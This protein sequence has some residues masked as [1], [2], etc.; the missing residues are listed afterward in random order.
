M[1]SIINYD[2]IFHDLSRLGT[3]GHENCFIDLVDGQL[4]PRTTKGKFNPKEAHEVTQYFASFVENQGK[5]LEGNGEIRKQLTNL[6]RQFHQLHI[7]KEEWDQIDSKL[8]QHSK[9]AE[10]NQAI[11]SQRVNRAN[12]RE[13]RGDLTIICKNRVPVKAYTNILAL[14]GSQFFES[15]GNLKGKIG[16]ITLDFSM[17]PATVVNALLDIVESRLEF[18]KNDPL[19][20]LALED[21]LLLYM[22]SGQVEIENLRD[23]CG[24]ELIK[25]FAKDPT[26]YHKANLSLVKILLSNESEMKARSELDSKENVEAELNVE[27]EIAKQLTSR[28]QFD[29]LEN[30]LANEMFRFNYVDKESETLNELFATCQ[31]VSSKHPFIQFCLSRCYSKNKEFKNAFECAKL[32][33]SS[34]KGYAI[35]LLG[36]HYENGEGVDKD[37]TNAFNLYTEG[38]KRGS[39]AASELQL[40]CHIRG[41]GTPKDISLA[42]S[43]LENMKVRTAFGTYLLGATLPVIQGLTYL[44]QAA[45]LGLANAINVLGVLYFEGNPSLSRDHQEALKLFRRAAVLGHPS[46]LVNLAVLFF[47]GEG[48]KENFPNEVVKRDVVKAEEYL[49]NAFDRGSEWGGWCLIKNTGS[50]HFFGAEATIMSIFNKFNAD[51]EKSYELIKKAALSGALNTNSLLWTAESYYRHFDNKKSY[52][53]YQIIAKRGHWLTFRN[54]V[55]ELLKKDK[56]FIAYAILNLCTPAKQE[57]DRKEGTEI[58]FPEHDLINFFADFIPMLPTAK[59]E[60]MVKQLSIIDSPAARV[61]LGRC[62]EEGIGVRKDA[63]IANDL[64]NQAAREKYPPA[65]IELGRRA[66]ANKESSSF[67]VGE[68]MYQQAAE[69]GSPEAMFRLATLYEKGTKD[70]KSNIGEAVLFYARAAE[71]DFPGARRGLERAR[72]A[73]EKLKK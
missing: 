54:G 52:E 61:I 25:R 47:N 39:L 37:S 49:L 38:A 44:N 23:S 73:L 51:R 59:A 16:N 63:R 53:L 48:V 20:E 18:A 58:R 27:A 67:K 8:E 69:L 42:T 43:T 34:G 24:E 36:R 41:F 50:V 70:V 22:L 30:F 5:L 6:S 40:Y 64:Y 33:A 13:E 68:A 12:K 3:E 21:L 31:S 10:V 56:N 62:Y 55:N 45:D 60:E 72:K 57:A 2:N 35:A 1:T 66:I 4:I 7:D 28:F 19:L 26:N 32:A 15:F 65:F 17:Y 11:Q 71:A 29:S 14:T 9:L 46:S